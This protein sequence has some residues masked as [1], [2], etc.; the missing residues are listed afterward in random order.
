MTNKTFQIYVDGGCRNN[1]NC[2]AAAYG[3]YKLLFNGQEKKH[4]T[5][6]LPGCQTN[7]EAEYESM[8]QALLYLQGLAARMAEQQYPVAEYAIEINCDSELVVEQIAGRRRAKKATMIEA[9]HKVQSVIGTL[10][11]RFR[12]VNI[13][14]VERA[15]IVEQLGH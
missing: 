1:G 6:E 13:H 2:R 3:S 9:L 14:W 4:D 10:E 7:N 5:F 12:K 15:I 8:H 11:K